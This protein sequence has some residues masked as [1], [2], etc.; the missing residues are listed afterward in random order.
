MSDREWFRTFFLG[1]GRES[2]AGLPLGSVDADTH[3][4]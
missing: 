4:A 1:H 3:A 2:Q